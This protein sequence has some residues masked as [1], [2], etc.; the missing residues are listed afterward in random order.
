MSSWTI[1]MIDQIE[2]HELS[3]DQHRHSRLV[4]YIDAHALDWWDIMSWYPID[5]VSFLVRGI[6]HQEPL[7]E[8]VTACFSGQWYVDR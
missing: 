1:L 4:P 8:R 6:V 2:Q 7:D 5:G 3:V